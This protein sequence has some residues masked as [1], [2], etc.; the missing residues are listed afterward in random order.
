MEI[1]TVLKS[2]GLLLAIGALAACGGGGGGGPSVANAPTFGDVMSDTSAGLVVNVL[3]AN[4]GTVAADSGR[5]D[6]AENLG[7]IGGLSGILSADRTRIDLADGGAVI[8]TTVDDRF[9]VRFDAAQPG[10]TTSGIAGVVTATSD[11]P[12]GTATYTGDTELTARTATDVFD[13]RG[14]ATITADFVGEAE[15]T[16]V[17]SDLSGVQQPALAAATNVTDVGTLTLSGSRIAGGLFS[18]GTATLSSDV[19]TLTG[20]ETVAVSGAFYGPGGAEAG[21]VFAITGGAT[22]IFGDFIAD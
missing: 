5:L 9:A 6:R 3:D 21:G 2:S 15:V 12:G 7:E 16:T 10:I 22:D 11:L 1:R 18:G 4:A 20:E 13:L 17:L 8:F 14:T 19:F